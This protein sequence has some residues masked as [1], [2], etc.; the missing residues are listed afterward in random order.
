M[1]EFC[2]GDCAEDI[3]IVTLVAACCEVAGAAVRRRREI[4][5]RGGVAGADH[6]RPTRG[7]PAPTAAAARAQGER[8]AGRRP[9]EVPAA[10]RVRR[11]NAPTSR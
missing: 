6:A 9:A 1:H 4:S 3:M 2:D 10:G 11:P 7:E 5:T 8:A